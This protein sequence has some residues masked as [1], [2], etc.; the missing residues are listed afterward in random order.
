MSF[1]TFP[2][3]S[4]KLD[5]ILRLLQD[6]PEILNRLQVQQKAIVDRISQSPQI[7]EAPPLPFDPRTGAPVLT[8]QWQQIPRTN[9]VILQTPA[10]PQTNPRIEMLLEQ[11]SQR[12]VSL[13]NQ[14]V[15]APPSQD[16]SAVLLGLN[17]GIGSLKHAI[18]MRPGSSVDLQP[19]I[20]QNTEI[21][22]LISDLQRQIS[23]P[24]GDDQTKSM[25]NQ[26]MTLLQQIYQALSELIGQA[27]DNHKVISGL[28]EAINNANSLLV[29][30]IN[31]RGS[32]IQQLIDENNAL[33]ENLRTLLS[34]LQSKRHH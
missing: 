34:H 8:S 11:I 5:I 17:D 10:Q 21:N 27:N 9:P 3:I 23:A 32:D 24:K 7:I 30:N 22:R 13:E 15:S 16:F 18:N 33:R 12:I 26:T 31:H 1:E 25:L 4:R 28:Q 19:I 2:D 20:N 14:R 6:Q 29:Q